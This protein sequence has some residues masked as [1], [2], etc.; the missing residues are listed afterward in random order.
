MTTSRKK[1]LVHVCCAA[2]ASYVFS[3]LEKEGF[4]I[5]AYFYNPEIH[6]HAE[7]LRRLLDVKKLCEERDIKLIVP[8]YDIQ[9]FFTLL[10][11]YQDKNSIKYITDKKRYRR[12]R[13]QICITLLI[14]DMVEKTKSLRLKNFTTT[15]LCSPYKDHDEIGNLSLESAVARNLNF[16]YKDF[17][18]GYWTGRNF[19]RT[20]KILIP[21]Y[22]GCN[23]SLDEGRLE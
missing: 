17:R 7:Y 12:K 3:E 18:K 4:T 6:G 11:P 10:M 9:D 15:M 21:K 22:C 13:C 19:A 16:F 8:E 14:K 20:H 23:E 5:V 1:I 2:C